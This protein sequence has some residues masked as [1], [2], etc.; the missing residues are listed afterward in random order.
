MFRDIITR[1]M[2]KQGKR[3][4]FVPWGKTE[5]RQE[6]SVLPHGAK[7]PLLPWLAIILVMVCLIS[8]AING[9][10]TNWRA[11]WYRLMMHFLP[12]WYNWPHLTQNQ[13]R[14]ST[15]REE[16]WHLTLSFCSNTTIQYKSNWMFKEILQGYRVHE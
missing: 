12:M 6:G 11:T 8:A 15:I 13:W 7:V 9:D 2:T 5:L 3:D 14:N 10:K 4:T 1:M 16:N